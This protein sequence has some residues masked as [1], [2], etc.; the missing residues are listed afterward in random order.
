VNGV[1]NATNV[2]VGG[3]YS[4]VTENNGAVA[5]SFTAPVA[6]ENLV[7][8][9]SS[10]NLVTAG[11]TNFGTL[12]YSLDGENYDTEIPTAVE[13]QSY[14]VYY[15]VDS[16][17]GSV[18]DPQTIEVSIAPKKSVQN[19]ELV[20][21]ER[22]VYTGSAICPE[23]VVKDGEKTLVLGT[24]YTV[25]CEN[26]VNVGDKATI[27]VFG[28]GNYTDSHYGPV[29]IVPPE[30]LVSDAVRILED[31]NGKHVEIDAEYSGKE[32]V[33]VPDAVAVDFVEVKRN[34]VPLT[35][36]TIVLPVQLPEGTT[37]NAKFFTLKEV[38]QV[39][40]S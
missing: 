3:I 36:A 20:Y 34:L 13:A 16:D 4:D 9:K 15:K 33:S 12:L 18:V 35:P 22:P 11:K 19:F 40:C 10:Q 6:A 38:K 14:T 37:F 39:G 29:M 27:G 17:N 30:V 24:D 7:Y 25:E 8:N 2:G 28:I 21:D 5:V 26:N 32:P 1:E 23:V 31:Q